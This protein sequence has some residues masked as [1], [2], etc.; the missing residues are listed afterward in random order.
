[1]AYTIR[2]KVAWDDVKN[3]VNQRT[4]GVSFEEASDLFRSG[5]DYLEIFDDEHS[6]TED[7]FIAIG[8]IRR[9]L[10]LVVLDRARRRNDSDH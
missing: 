7:R 1:M 3:R 10:V 4:H 6:V 9:G 8:P 2:V 5:V